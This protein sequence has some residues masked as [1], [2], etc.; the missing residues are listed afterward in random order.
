M[1]NKT[2]RTKY[3]DKI[4][5]LNCSNL[6]CA[7][8]KRFITNFQKKKTIIAQGDVDDSEGSRDG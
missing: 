5:R 4:I 3:I 7:L 6:K 8:M 2:D 1:S